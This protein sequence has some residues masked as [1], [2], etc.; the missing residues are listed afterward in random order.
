MDY[1]FLVGRILLG[2]FFLLNAYNHFTAVSSMVPYAKSKGVPAPRMA[3]LGSGL[4]IA[5][6]GLSILLGV[7]PKCGVL[8]LALFLVPVTFTMHNF[9][10]DQDQQT[11][12]SN[13]VQFQKNLAL[14]GASLMLLLVPEPWV[15]SLGR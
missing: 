12:Q 2:G 10:A 13:E 11:R 4:L 7:K 14:L 1:L 6:G 15:L 5:L 9:W 3:I 8:L